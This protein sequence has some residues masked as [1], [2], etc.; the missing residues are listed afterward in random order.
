MARK[1]DH[2]IVEVHTSV[3]LT[4]VVICSPTVGHDV[5][6]RKV[7]H[8][9]SL[10]WNGPSRSRA[11][12]GAVIIVFGGTIHVAAAGRPAIAVSAVPKK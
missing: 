12:A 3:Q 9:V 7:N 8:D 11:I 4:N 6:A 10:S 1:V 5:C 2:N